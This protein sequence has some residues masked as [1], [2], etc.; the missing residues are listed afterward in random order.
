AGNA[1]KRPPRTGP[2]CRASSPAT[3]VMAPPKRKRT[4]YSYHR[5]RRKADKFRRT[6]ITHF[7]RR[8]NQMPKA[9]ANQ[10]ASASVVAAV[11]RSLVFVSRRVHTHAY[12]RNA[13]LPA[14]MERA[15]TA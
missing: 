13:A 2:K 11:A 12:A 3:K 4:A 1:R 5:V 9:P 7:L 8:K 14:S 6:L 15:S 10:T